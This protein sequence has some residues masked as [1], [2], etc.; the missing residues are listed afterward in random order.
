ELLKSQTLRANEIEL[1]SLFDEEKE[2]IE[3]MFEDFSKNLLNRVSDNE[4]DLT[5]IKNH[6]LEEKN[7]LISQFESL[8]DDINNI[9]EDNR[10]ESLTEDKSKLENSLISLREDFEKVEGLENNL[11]E[12]KN[13]ID[14]IDIDLRGDI[15]TLSDKLKDFKVNLENKIDSDSE[16]LFED[17]ASLNKDFE[18]IKDNLL[19]SMSKAETIENKIDSVFKDLSNENK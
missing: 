10:I 2:R 4:S 19:S 11:L 13:K 8:R 6:L 16:S 14:G 1:P 17:L 7:N 5:Y 3:N 12:L 15:E 9:R 18:S